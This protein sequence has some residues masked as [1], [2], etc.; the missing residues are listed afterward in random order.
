M[1]SENQQTIVPYLSYE[2]APAAL[3]FLKQAFGF[4]EVERYPM[5]DGRIGHASVKL[6]GSSLYLASAFPDMG[7]V[8]PQ[9]LEGIHSQVYCYVDDL[10]AHYAQAVEAGAIIINEPAMSEGG[11][12]YRALDPEGH[13]W[14]FGAMPS[15]GSSSN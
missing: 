12:L 2:D 13:R 8:S 9:K 6:G 3:D 7:F 1:A 14:L 15:E 5:P 4:E 11:R 10:D